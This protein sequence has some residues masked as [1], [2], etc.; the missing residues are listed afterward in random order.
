MSHAVIDSSRD[1]VTNL[2]LDEETV[3]IQTKNGFISALDSRSGAQRWA[4]LL[5]RLDTPQFPLISNSDTVLVNAGMSMFAVDKW[6]G[7]ELWHI[8]LPEQVST[9]PAMDEERVFLAT[10]SGSVYAFDLAKV[11]ELYRQHKLPEWGYQARLW[12]HRTSKAIR[13]SPLSYDGQITFA[14]ETKTIYSVNAADDSLVFQMETPDA[15]TAPIVRSE[16]KLFVAT[17]D[18]RLYCLNAQRGTTL[19]I[20]IARAN[21]PAAPNLIN[22]RCYVSPND[23]SLHCLN[24]ETGVLLWEQ[25]GARGVLAE[26]E[27]YVVSQD[28]LGNVLLISPQEEQQTSQ[29]IARLPLRDFSIRAENELTDRIYL[30]TPSGMVICLKEKGISYPKFFKNPDKR[31]LEPIFTDDNAAA[32]VEENAGAF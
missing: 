7:S 29:I 25:P 21:I 26:T 27:N 8:N 30:A 1:R 9:S 6:S 32:P 22:N 10:G 11:L 28:E 15:V 12:R 23:G 19:W 31:P 14:S 5:A 2:V 16:D 18:Q 24:K 17:G 20:F 3:Y 13:Y 4:Q